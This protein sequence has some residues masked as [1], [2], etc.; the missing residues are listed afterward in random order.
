MELPEEGLEMTFESKCPPMTSI[1]A[2]SCCFEVILRVWYS[3]R[4]KISPLSVSTTIAPSLET[5]KK[6]KYEKVF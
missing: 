5:K 6:E 1:L 2:T 4:I 3:W